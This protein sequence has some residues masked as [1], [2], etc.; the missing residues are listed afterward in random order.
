MYPQTCKPTPTNLTSEMSIQTIGMAMAFNYRY[1][2][3]DIW[4]VSLDGNL[5][6]VD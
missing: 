2:N 6:I 4:A 1:L 5:Q 3:F